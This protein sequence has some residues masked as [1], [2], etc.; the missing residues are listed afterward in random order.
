MCQLSIDV[1]NCL[2]FSPQCSPSLA[3]C[4]SKRRHSGSQKAKGR[5]SRAF[6]GCH[7]ITNAHLGQQTSQVKMI[8]LILFS[9]SLGPKKLASM[10]LCVI[11]PSYTFV[12]ACLKMWEILRDKNV[13]C[14]NNCT[15]PQCVE[16]ESLQQC[17]RHATAAP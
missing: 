16:Q 1:H 3:T 17:S 10:Y 2:L 4:F 11:H 5:L 7:S 12:A 8:S 13:H 15:S 9:P 14:K 6:C